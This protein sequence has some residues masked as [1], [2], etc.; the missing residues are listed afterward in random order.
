[1]ATQISRLRN[2]IIEDQRSQPSEATKWGLLIT[3]GLLLGYGF[4]RGSLP[5]LVSAAVGAGVLYLGLSEEGQ[6]RVLGHQQP[7]SPEPDVQEDVV[8]EASWESFPAS[9]APAY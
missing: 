4:M 7:A 5:G 2:A 8:D 6:R 9:D 3:G 1:M